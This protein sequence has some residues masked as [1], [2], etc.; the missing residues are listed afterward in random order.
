MILGFLVI[1]FDRVTKWYALTAFK[2]EVVVNKFLS[3]QL[4]FNRGISWG[5]FYYRDPLV[6]MGITL[7]IMAVTAGLIYY[8]VKRYQ[9]GKSI[10]GETLVIAGALSNCY[11]R[12]VY[13]GVI[14]F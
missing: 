12:F 14:D 5:M 7:L 1:L 11:D 2:Q 10:V 9:E 4:T 6:F 13:Q 8:S 3:F